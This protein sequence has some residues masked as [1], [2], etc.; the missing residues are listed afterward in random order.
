LGPDTE[1]GHSMNRR[2]ATPRAELWL[3]LGAAASYIATGF[4]VKQIFA[5]WW[6]GAI[7]FVAFVWL[8][9]KLDRRR[10]VADTASP[11]GR[12]MDGT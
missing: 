8:V 10:S 6:F 7:W 12:G 2:E 1:V 3:Y 5:W 11:T 4:L 9:P